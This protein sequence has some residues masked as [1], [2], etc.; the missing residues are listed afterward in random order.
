VFGGL[1][2]TLPEG[3]GAAPIRPMESGSLR[4]C[5]VLRTRG[6]GTRESPLVVLREMLDARVVLGCICDAG[7]RVHEWVEL[8]VQDPSGLAGAPVLY[9]ESWTN[10]RLDKKWAERA[11]ELER[12]DQSGAGLGAGG[13]IRTGMEREHPMPMFVSAK[14]LEPLQARD[15]TTGAAWALCTDDG[16]LS[17]KGLPPYSGSLSRHLY[18][19]ELG[20][21]GSFVPVEVVD[22]SALGL[23]PDAVGLNPGAGLM[24]VQ[25]YC[26]LSYE[27]YVD[28]IGNV[29][30]EGGNPEQLL[31]NIAAAATGETLR[32]GAGWLMLGG[33]ALGQGPA[34]RLVEALHLKIMVFAAAV[35]AVRASVSTSGAPMLNLTARSFRVRLGDGGGVVPLFWTARVA[36][37]QPGESVE[38]PIPGTDAKYFVGG[39]GGAISVYAPAGL[40]QASTGRGWLRWRNITSDGTGA[41]IAE[42][43]LSTQDKVV[44]GKNDLV[45][46]RYNL[47][48][49][50]VD[51]YAVVDVKGSMSPGEV[52]IRTI[53]QAVSENMAAQLRGALGVPVPEV[54][55]EV[56]PLLSTPCDLYALGVLG[57]RT[58]LTTK[59]QPLPAALDEL[60]SL[61]GKVAAQSDSGE[62]LSARVERVLTEEK[63]FAETLGP[64]VV[65]AVGLTPIEA[66]EVIPARLWAQALASLI[67]CFT[68]LGP[69]SRCRDFGDAPPGGVHKVFDGLLEDLYALLIACRTLIVADHRLNAEVRAVV[70]ECMAAAR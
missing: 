54:A 67:R 36:L 65:T 66:M 4:L 46:L 50:R 42:G 52:R 59:G 9:R 13:L 11:D 31:R 5:V 55:F 32:A 29:E 19:P 30:G 45:W 24:L 64:Q 18:Q 33:G 10:A 25:R 70:R 57:V 6:V 63:R 61:S 62:E 39:R 27:E 41:L 68:G 26:P 38:L 40:A 43:T 20:E 17:R 2:R 47:G 15:K 48:A 12:L 37:V 44:P 7:N 8:W 21:G 22:G 16:M 3:Y 23:G 35:G 1:P 69:D 34:A 51:Q 56:L 60:M 53:P 28:A 14:S 58:L 49:I